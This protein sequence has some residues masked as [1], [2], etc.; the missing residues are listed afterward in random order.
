M[1]SAEQ[2][3]AF[4][5]EP[6]YSRVARLF[7]VTQ[8]NTR[9]VLTD[10]EFRARYGPWKVVTPLTNIAGAQLTGPYSYLKTVGPAHYSFSDH[11]LTFATN[12][13]QGVCLEFRLPIKGAPFGLVRHP[14]LTV[15]VA[16]GPGL[17]AAIGHRR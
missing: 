14:N 16:D 13:R 12:G 1:T 7:G 2:E 5:F 10:T 8:A 3:F 4:A 9:V 17:I 6:S 11:G 15:T